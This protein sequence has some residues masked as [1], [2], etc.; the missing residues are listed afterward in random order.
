MIDNYSTMILQISTMFSWFAR[1]CVLIFA[2]FPV[3]WSDNPIKLCSSK[4]DA[5]W[6]NMVMNLEVRGQHLSWSAWSVLKRPCHCD[7]HLFV[8]SSFRR[9]WSFAGS[10]SRPAAIECMELDG[11]WWGWR[12]D[13][14]WMEIGGDSEIFWRSWAVQLAPSSWDICRFPQLPSNASSWFGNDRELA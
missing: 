14:D 8:P 6:C 4:N 7:S 1:I 10:T 13:G 9:C 2:A 12:L 11:A 5:K 3:V